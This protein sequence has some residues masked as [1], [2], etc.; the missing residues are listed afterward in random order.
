MAEVLDDVTPTL[1]SFYIRVK[2]GLPGNQPASLKESVRVFMTLSKDWVVH[3]MAML[4]RLV[5]LSS[6]NL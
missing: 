6:F 5:I 2:G 3:F 1:I 4:K